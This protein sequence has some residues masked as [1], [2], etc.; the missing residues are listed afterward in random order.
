MG[1][2]DT[3]YLNAPSVLRL[4]S[5]EDGALEEQAAALLAQARRGVT[6][7]SDKRDY[8]TFDQ[9]QLRYRHEVMNHT[10]IADESLRSGLFRRAHNE[11][12]NS[13]PTKRLHAHDDY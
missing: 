7:L 3:G 4:K 11:L 5:G 6:A 12:A 8:L 10:G 9:L 13:R 2:L 1:S